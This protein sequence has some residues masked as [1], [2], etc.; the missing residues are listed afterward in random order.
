MQHFSFA[1]NS[2]FCCL[3]SQ[4]AHE[5]K[6]TSLFKKHFSQQNADVSLDVLALKRADWWTTAV[7]IKLWAHSVGLDSY[8]SQEHS[9]AKRQTTE[10]S[11]TSVKVWQR[12]STP[13]AAV[14]VAAVG[15]APPLHTNPGWGSSL[16]PVILYFVII[17]GLDVWCK[18]F[19]DVS[20]HNWGVD[21][22]LECLRCSW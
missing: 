12:I 20:N 14:R 19:P 7:I 8:L 11:T 17:R 21:Y 22:G 13:L 5:R 6:P 16:S 15:P 1:H 18:Q 9:Q 4:K 3:R 10:H 2:D